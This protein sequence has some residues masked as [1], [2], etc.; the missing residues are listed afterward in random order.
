MRP[1]IETLTFDFLDDVCLA[2][3]SNV[4]TTA[5]IPVAAAYELG[6][7]MELH[8]IDSTWPT[9]KNSQWLK[10]GALTDLV[11]QRNLDRAWVS[12][13]GDQIFVPGD[14]L[15]R[16]EIAWPDFVIKIKK[17]ALAAG[18]SDDI[19]GKLA[20]A[21]GELHNNILEHSLFAQ[22]GYIAVAAREGFI[23]FVVADKG[24]GVLKSLRSNPGLD[25]IKD[26]GT[27]L[28]QALQ[29]G[30]SR[31]VEPG[32]GLGFRPIFVG[33]ANISRLVRFRS[34]DFA[35]IIER[36]PNGELQSRTVQ[37]ANI[38]GFFCSVRCDVRASMGL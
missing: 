9:S 36:L 12:R 31:H 7:V 33:L 20:A 24:I 18:F 19:G 13:S 2:L 3:E 8:H 38:D 6:P 34:G 29:Q 22:T 10:L 30:V 32:R 17:A 5:E 23:E 26:A 35:R 4:V 27:A 25:W 16:Q 37:L 28:E 1:V 15:R 21:I 11:G 14:E